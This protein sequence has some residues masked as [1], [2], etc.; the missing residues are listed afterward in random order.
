MIEHACGRVLCWPAQHAL[1][2]I[3]HFAETAANS[4]RDQLAGGAIR[5]TAPML[6]MTATYL[7]VTMAICGAF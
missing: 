2:L 7:I 3:P 1:M 5:T 6:L 4:N